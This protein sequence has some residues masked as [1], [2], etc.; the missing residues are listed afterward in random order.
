[1]WKLEGVTMVGVVVE[2]ECLQDH[3][4]KVSCNYL[5][6]LLSYSCSLIKLLTCQGDEMRD[7]RER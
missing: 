2:A 6:F 4:L 3:I 7:E 5:D 1:M